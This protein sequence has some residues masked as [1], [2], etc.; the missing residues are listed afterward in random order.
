LEGPA[1]RGRHRHDGVDTKP[2]L[3]NK[4]AAASAMSGSEVSSFRFFNRKMSSPSS[5]RSVANWGWPCESC[6]RNSLL[7]VCWRSST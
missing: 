2:L 3:S 6:P 7:N 4:V 5:L 1:A